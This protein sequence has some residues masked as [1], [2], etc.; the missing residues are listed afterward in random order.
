[1]AELRKTMC[2]RDCP[3]VCS[4]VATV[5][6]GKVIRLQ[7][8]KAH[9]VTQGFL[10][11]RTN[12][13]PELMYSPQRLTSPL[14]RKN[15]ELVPV[16]WDEALDF[17]AERLLAI[18]AES[19]PAAIFHFRSAGAMGFVKQVTS[20][21][22]EQFG[23]VTD[24]RGDICSGAGE[25]A[26]I[27]DFGDYE[28]SDPSDLE[29]AK[30]I[31][32]WG[33]NVYV[34][35]THSL[36]LLQAAK[37]RGVAIVGIDPIHNRTA[38][39][40]D[41]FWQPRPG[42]DYALAMATARV[43]FD[44]GWTHP[45]AARWTENLD[46]FRALVERRTAQEW[47]ADADLPVAAAID[48]AEQLHDG[49]TTIIVGWGM[50]RR[51]NGAGIVRALD[52]LGVITGNI[53][54][55]GG[56]VAFEAKRRRAFDLSFIQNNAPRTICEPQIGQGILEATD[57]PVRAVW[58]TAGNPVAMMPES[59]KTAHALRTR[60]LV[61]VVDPFFTDTAACA[62]VVLPTTTLLEDDDVLGSYGHHYVGVSQ[63]VVPAPAFVRS[64]LQIIQALAARVGLADKVAGDARTWKQRILGKLAE[65]GITLERLERE[66]PMKHPFVTEIP[67]VDRTFATA[68]GKATLMTDDAAPSATPSAEFPMYLM[69][70]STNAQ[71]ASQAAHP[72]DG[73]LECTVHPAST[74]LAHGALARLESVIGSIEVRVLHD[75]Q[76]R[77]DVA[78][79]PKGGRHREGRC[80]NVLIRARLSDHGEGAALG[81]ELVRLVPLQ[82]ATQVQ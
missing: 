25:A 22:F 37:K 13:Y 24:K 70:L 10:C 41:R 31:I 63:P 64:D 52:A 74:T 47:C 27:A 43:L 11:R 33:R 8:D 60:E 32:I 73:P 1:V 75:P 50:G 71:Q 18:R 72:L 30:R 54:I 16:S 36:P 61:V 79:V 68:S 45:E 39:L 21:F 77:R 51:L 3:D 26:Q 49:P 34:S 44:R 46:T 81:D 56:G 19:G 66:G 38:E 78:L 55:P 28:T 29:N 17:V 48:L 42:G 69:S 9:P 59:D 62:T 80:A 58:I 82:R 15:G 5:E 76:Q 12:E 20:Y 7:G 14:L 40:C 53:G 23:P 4:I 2:N 65:R 57:P 35:W 67:W 6:D